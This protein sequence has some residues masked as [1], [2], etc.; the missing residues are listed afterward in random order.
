MMILKIWNVL[1]LAAVSVSALSILKPRQSIDNPACASN[2]TAILIS[3]ESCTTPGCLCNNS[4]AAQVLDCVD[5]A[6]QKEATP[7]DIQDDTAAL[8]A[9]STRCAAAGMPLIPLTIAVPGSTTASNPGTA[10]TTASP[11]SPQSSE[12]TIASSTSTSSGGGVSS[13]GSATTS[14]FTSSSSSASSSESTSSPAPTTSPS[15]SGSQTPTPTGTPAPSNT[16]SSITSETPAPT[17]G[18]GGTQHMGVPSIA[19]YI[20]ALA[21]GAL[22]V[23]M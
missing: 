14:T 19:L 20:T 7:Q 15:G 12:T 1:L 11:S 23:C 9:Y 10:S 16:P 2:C 18:T 8:N 5:C 6:V 3:I 22:V 21:L 17:S 13:S 4:T